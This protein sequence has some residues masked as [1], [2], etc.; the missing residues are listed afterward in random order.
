MNF[1][2]LSNPGTTQDVFVTIIEDQVPENT[3]TFPLTVRSDDLDAVPVISS[4]TGIITDDDC[5]SIV[6]TVSVLST[7][8][9][10]GH[11]GH[12]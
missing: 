12:H 11:F 3:E 2:A 5:E 6:Y 1:L 8:V 10:G 9:C 7:V 4:A